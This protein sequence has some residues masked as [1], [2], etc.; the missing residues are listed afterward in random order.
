MEQLELTA[1]PR[2]IGGGDKFDEYPYL[3]G[4]PRHPSEE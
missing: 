3:G 4:G 1:D 2:V